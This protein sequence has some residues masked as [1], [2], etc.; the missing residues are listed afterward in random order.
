MLGGEQHA[1]AYGPEQDVYG[2]YEFTDGSWA[3]CF[4]FPEG[5]QAWV[6]VSLDGTILPDPLDGRYPYSDR[7]AE[8]M[9]TSW[10]ETAAKRLDEPW[11]S[12]AKVAIRAAMLED[13]LY[14]G[15]DEAAEAGAGGEYTGVGSRGN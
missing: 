12:A 5:T 15:H 9:L 10:E 1:D 11:H 2:D 6:I 4:L 7:A 14:W 3:V 13:V 8:T